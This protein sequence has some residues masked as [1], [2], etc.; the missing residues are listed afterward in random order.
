MKQG[1][2]VGQYRFLAGGRGTL[3]F[4]LPIGCSFRFRLRSGH[5][6]VQRLALLLVEFGMRQRLARHHL[7]AHGGVVNE[8]RLNHGRLLQVAGNER[9]YTSILV[10][11]LR[12]S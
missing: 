4:V 7:I 1:G 2:K 5:R 3:S 9:S 8:D 10:W 12:V 11:A 6:V